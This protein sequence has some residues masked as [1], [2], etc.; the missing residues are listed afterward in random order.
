[1]SSPAAAAMGEGSPSHDGEK[2]DGE[3][4]AGDTIGREIELFSLLSPQLLLSTPANLS[5][6]FT[7]RLTAWSLLCCTDILP[8][9]LDLGVQLLT[10]E[11]S[12]SVSHTNG[13]R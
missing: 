1:M 13:G 12:E 10:L 11:G 7:F 8:I 4:A 6:R 2:V 5:S 9:G 3:P